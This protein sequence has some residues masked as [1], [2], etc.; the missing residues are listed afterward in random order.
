MVDFRYTKQETAW[1][2]IR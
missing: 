2:V 1:I